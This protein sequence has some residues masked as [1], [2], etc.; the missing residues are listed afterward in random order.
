MGKYYKPIIPKGTHLAQ[1]HKSK[2]AMRG[3]LLDNKTN[4]I[5]G[6]AEFE[7]IFFP[8]RT[9]EQPQSNAE[10]ME[11]FDQSMAGL[12]G[13]ISS[14]IGSIQQIHH[15]QIEIEKAKASMLTRDQ[16]LY[17]IHKDDDD[18]DDDD[19]Y[20]HQKH[21]YS[22]RKTN[23]SQWQKSNPQLQRQKAFVQELKK[24]REIDYSI[25]LEKYRRQREIQMEYELKMQRIK[26]HKR[27]I[28]RERFSTCFS[29]IG[30]A[31]WFIIKH[32]GIGLW[33]LIKYIGLGIAWIATHSFHL[34]IR[35][36]KAIRTKH[37]EQVR[38]KERLIKIQP[39][40]D[41]ISNYDNHDDE[42]D[43]VRK[44]PIKTSID[45]NEFNCLVEQIYDNYSSYTIDDEKK[46]HLINILIL[47]IHLA[48][49]IRALYSTDDVSLANSKDY[50]AW[51][52]TMEKMASFHIVNLV[53]AVLEKNN[54]LIPQDKMDEIIRLFHA[55]RYENGVYIPIS[56]SQVRELLIR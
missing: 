34:I 11:H 17:G 14:L 55:G 16:I 22:S 53:N 20:M 1:S 33:L 36:I 32:L 50:Q 26:A 28:R 15:T 5:V 27:E 38:N 51:Q 31:C 39:F 47:S 43:D 45:Q 54:A 49:E 30:N 19:D 2:G 8:D 4:K 44:E 13:S 21:N 41:S 9:L 29:A 56:Q 23:F 40:A 12:T 10:L 46:I 3:T 35:G 37:Q 24:K 7:E 52:K 6:Q 25:D 48:N 42:T 18:N